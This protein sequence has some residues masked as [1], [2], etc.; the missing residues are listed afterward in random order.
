MKILSIDTSCDETAAAVTEDTKILSNIIWS[1]ASAH[2]KFGGVMPSLAQR[3]HEERIDFVVKKA[4]GKF[5]ISKN[6]DAIAVTV[7]PGLSIALR[8]GVNKAKELALKYKKRLIAVNHLE[9]HILSSLANSGITNFQFSISNL[10]FPALGLVISGKNTQ[11]I[12]MDKIGGYKILA[13]THD[14]AL[15]E[16]LDKA[17]RMLGLGYPGGAIFEK[18]AELGNSKKYKLPVPMA[19]QE[20]RRMFSY[21]GLKTSMMRLVES[22]K[23]LTKEKIY[24]L[25]ASFQNIAFTHVTRVLHF[26]LSND[27]PKIPK[28]LLVG[29]GVGINVEMR[30]RLRKLGKAFNIN[31]HFPYSNRLYGDNAAMIGIA[32]YFK[33][34]RE[35][36][37]DPDKI[38]RDPRAKL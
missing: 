4:L 29:G 6:I 22:E 32:A 30:K 34:E 18:M 24:D 37:V 1:Q 33:A 5:D 14:D 20:N 25:A 38:D 36:F 23:P 15:G 2:A 16:A 27:Y 31:L 12:Q 7:G 13:E 21:S 8:V 19:G 26:I 17:A 9:G 10:K 35:E 28:D 11:I 3:M